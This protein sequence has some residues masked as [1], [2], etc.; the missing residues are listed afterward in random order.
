MIIIEATPNRPILLGKNG[1]NNTREITFNVRD[2]VQEY[3][4]GVIT[5]NHKRAGDN[6]GQPTQILPVVDGVAAWIVTRTD[7]KYHGFGEAE[8][9]LHDGDQVVKTCT[10]QTYT[11]KQVGPVETD[12][13]EP[14][15]GYAEQ[16]IAAGSAAVQAADEAGQQAENAA[17]AAEDAEAAKDAADDAQEAAETAQAAAETAQEAAEAAQAAAE[18]ASNS[19]GSA[20]SSAEQDALEA[21]GYARG[22]Q[23]GEPVEE[24]SPYYHASARYHAQQACGYSTNAGRKAAEAE[25]SAQDAQ[26]SADEA[27]QALQSVEQL[28]ADIDALKALGLSVINGKVC[29][30]YER[31]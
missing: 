2:W 14:L 9:E 16:V 1:T 27:A 13:P 12:V 23:D 22:T 31:G 19:A 4:D 29:Q 21:E 25:A 3:P 20:A 26:E 24:G 18:A 28:I 10:Y 15:A 7:V 30:T 8:L 11:A 17:A 6:A 5:L